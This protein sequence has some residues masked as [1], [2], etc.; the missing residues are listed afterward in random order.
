MRAVEK[1]NYTHSK[2]ST[3]ATWWEYFRPLRAIAT[4]HVGTAQGR[5]RAKRRPQLIME[6]PPEEMGTAGSMLGARGGAVPVAGGA[7][8][9]DGEEEDPSWATFV[10]DEAAES[11]FEVASKNSPQGEHAAGAGCAAAT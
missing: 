6:P 8:E 4:S 9:A 1:F 7:R 3:Y 5:A 11:P 2:F 10:E